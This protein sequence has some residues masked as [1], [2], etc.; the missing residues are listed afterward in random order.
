MEFDEKELAEAYVPFQK[1]SRVSCPEKS[2]IDGTA[3]P[4]LCKPYTKQEKQKQ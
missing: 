3:Y 4:E 2:L 1:P